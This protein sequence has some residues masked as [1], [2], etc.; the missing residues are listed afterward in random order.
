M[1]IL[2]SANCFWIME[3]GSPRDRITGW[4]DDGMALNAH[5]IQLGLYLTSM[6]ACLSTSCHKQSVH[7]YQSQGIPCFQSNESE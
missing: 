2:L 4:N 1:D 7:D 6:P 3:I 5:P